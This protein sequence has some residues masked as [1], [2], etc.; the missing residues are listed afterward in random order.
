MN[1]CPYTVRPKK[2]MF[3]SASYELAIS[4]LLAKCWVQLN[5]LNLETE[6]GFSHLRQVKNTDWWKRASK[7]SKDRTESGWMSE[8]EGVIA[9]NPRKIRGDRCYRLFLEEAG[10]NKN[11][12]TSWIQGRPLVIRGGKRMGTRFAWGTGGDSGPALQGLSDMFYN[13][14]AYEILPFKHNYTNTGDTVLTGFF[15]PAYRMHFSFLDER[16]VT[17][18]IK[19]KEEFEKSRNLLKIDPKSYIEECSEYCFT[20]EDALIRQGENQFNQAALADQLANLLIHKSVETP[21]KG[22]LK[23]RD[24]IKMEHAKSEDL[25]WRPDAN[26]D[27]LVLEEPLKDEN[28]DVFKNLYVAGIDSIDLGTSDSTGQSDVSDFCIV[29]KKRIHGIKEPKY[30]AMY[31][32]RPKDIRFAYGNAI[33][34]LEW[35]NCQALLEATRVSILT[36]AR[37]RK[38]INLF[39]KRP[40]ATMTDLNKGNSNMYGSPATENIIKHYLQL[41]ENYVNDYSHTI[42]YEE[43]LNQLLKYDYANKRKFDIIAAMGIKCCPSLW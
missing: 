2:R 6:G 26:G 15:F 18:E 4:K 9:D 28:G 17:D 27:I 1:V 36:Y 25:V 33:R 11:L 39:M 35:Y 38:K 42:A 20:P 32:A 30:V 31:K 5:W 37:E 40:R 3:N 29:I 22:F 8:I 10:S 7:F 21:K 14:Q 12:K 34:L 19:A 23:Y 13:P 41:I 43:I 16:G 24:N